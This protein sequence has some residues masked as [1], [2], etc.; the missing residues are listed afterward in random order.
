MVLK[1]IK[2][3]LDNFLKYAHYWVF[4]LVGIL[5]AIGT[6]AKLFG[7]WNISSDWFWFLGGLGLIVEGA[8]SLIKQKR[9]D[10]KYKIVEIGRKEETR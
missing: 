3:K 10:K 2:S 4:I 6:L 1:R 5:M 8:I 9:F 7:F